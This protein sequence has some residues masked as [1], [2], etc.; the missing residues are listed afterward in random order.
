MIDDSPT[1]AVIY[2]DFLFRLHPRACVY[3]YTHSV[4]LLPAGWLQHDVTPIDA[5][6]TDD[7]RDDDFFFFSFLFFFFS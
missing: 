4:Y 3:V 2:L 6:Y 5:N 1:V 7:E